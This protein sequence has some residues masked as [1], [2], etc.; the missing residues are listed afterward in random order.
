MLQQIART[1]PSPSSPPT[2]IGCPGN[3][4]REWDRTDVNLQCQCIT[5]CWFHSWAKIISFPAFFPLQTS[6][7]PAQI[8]ALNWAIEFYTK[9]VS[10]PP[11]LFLWTNKFP[12]EC[13][14][15][16]LAN[17]AD[18]W[19]IINLVSAW[20]SVCMAELHPL[21]ADCQ[22]AP[23]LRLGAGRAERKC[24]HLHAS[25]CFACHANQ[26]SGGKA[27]AQPCRWLCL[28]LSDK[29]LAFQFTDWVLRGAAQ[30][31]FANNPLSGFVIF[32]GL[33]IQ[34][35]WWMITG[36]LGTVVSTLTALILSQDRWV[37]LYVG[38]GY[39]E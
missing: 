32:I 25:V 18:G 37:P 19:N 14:W 4:T 22:A 33:L 2:Y 29:P 38:L 11:H 5:Q 30:V 34:N 13:S 15:G 3:Q 10:F 17:Q 31:M 6:F 16:F 24:P 28:S 26:W 8:P 35:P 12:L 7:F 1:L 39:A 27:Q 21:W 20:H 9:R 23:R 36:G